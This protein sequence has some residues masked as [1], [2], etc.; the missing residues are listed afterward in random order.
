MELDRDD[1]VALCKGMTKDEV[2]RV[3]RLLHEWGIGPEDSFP[4]QLA[5]LTTAQ[6]RIAATLPRLMN[7]AQKLIE[8]HLT[9]Y[10]RQTKT[11]VDDFSAIADDKILE[12]KTVVETHAK[13]TLETADSIQNQLGEAKLVV[14]QIREQLQSGVTEWNRAKNKFA[15]ERWHFELVCRKLD[16]RLNW[17]NVCWFLVGAVVFLSLGILLGRHQ[18]K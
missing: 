15:D 4:V 11:T 12:L 8:R 16:E 13:A 2:D 10:Q 14:A 6:W 17:W 7:D 3:H 18:W 5:L 9:E 1:L